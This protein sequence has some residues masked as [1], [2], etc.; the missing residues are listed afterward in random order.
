MGYYI[1]QADIEARVSADV[2][3]RCYD[4]DNNATAD[5]APVAGLIADAE[6]YVEG[7]LRGVYSLATVRAAP[8]HEVKRYCLDVAVAY[9]RERFPSLVRV[10]GASIF[11]RVTRELTELRTQ[12]RRLDVDGSPEPGANQGG[13]IYPGVDTDIQDEPRLF[14]FS[15]TGLF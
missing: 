14:D 8:P 11:E 15:H 10:D 5:A 9:M 3:R 7:F 1:T 6:G 4:D 12:P 13:V 2:F